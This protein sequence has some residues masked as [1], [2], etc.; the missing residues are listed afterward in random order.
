MLKTS[1]NGTMYDRLSFYQAAWNSESTLLTGLHR[2]KPGEKFKIDFEDYLPDEVSVKMAYL[3]D[4]FDESL[5]PIVDVPVSN[6]EGTYEFVNPP[7]SD[8][9]ITT[10]GRVF[11]ISVTWDK[12]ICEY[13]FATDGKFDNWNE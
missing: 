12:N 3:T 1:W 6:V 13:V 5:L 8:S 10:S 7:A 2:P 4:S 9:S 11:S